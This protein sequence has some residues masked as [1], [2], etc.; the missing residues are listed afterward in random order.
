[1]N[2]KSQYYP[3]AHHEFVGKDANGIPRVYG[4]GPTPD[5]AESEC[6]K[7]MMEYVGRR[8]DTGPLDKWSLEKSN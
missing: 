8:P 1:M 6:R 3:K 5:V 4:N 2:T 7:A